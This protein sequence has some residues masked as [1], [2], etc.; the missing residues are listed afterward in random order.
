[1][2]FR[3]T[4][5]ED[6]ELHDTK[7]EAGDKV[8]MFYSSGNRDEARFER[9]GVF[10]LGRRSNPHVG[11]GGRGPHYCLGQYLAKTQLRL[12]FSELLGRLPDIRTEGDA[13]FM[14]STFINGINWVRLSWSDAHAACGMRL[15]A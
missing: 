5:T 15:S 7:I 6:Y 12:I 13:T 9:P 11:F 2:T 14:A 10:D 3:R 4:A 1:M 8:T